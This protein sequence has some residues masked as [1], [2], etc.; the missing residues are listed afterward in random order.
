[1]CSEGSQEFNKRA[2]WESDHVEVATGNTLCWLELRMLDTVC[3]GFIQ[4]IAGRYVGINFLFTV[5]AHQYR[6]RAT[7]SL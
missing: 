5:V 1:V 7:V 6:R 3:S 2:Q 4:W